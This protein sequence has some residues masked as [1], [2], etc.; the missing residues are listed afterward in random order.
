MNF[1]KKPKI[2]IGNTN[3][4]S[5]INDFKS[6]F[7][8]LG[9]RTMTGYT[10]SSDIIDD[11]PLDYCLREYYNTNAISSFLYQK[12]RP[13]SFRKYFTPKTNGYDYIF[14]KAIKE[15]DIFLFM[16]STFK[17]DLSDLKLLKKLKKKIIFFFVGSDIVW[18]QGQELDFKSKGLEP[19]EFGNNKAK[20]V[21]N[22]YER[23]RF[24]RIAEK[25]SDL[26]ITAPALAQLLRKPFQRGRHII[27]LNKIR[28]NPNQKLI[29]DVIFSPSCRKYKGHD[30]VINIIN[31]I[32]SSKSPKFNFILV[33]G[34]DYQ[35]ALKQYSD[36]DILIGELFY[37]GGGKQQR[38]ALASGTVVLTNFDKR[39]PNGLPTDTPF[40]HV[41]RHNLK[42]ELIKI[43]EDFSLRQSIAANGRSFIEN[44]NSPVNVCNHILE[45]LKNKDNMGDLIKPTFYNEIY[46]SFP[47][48][49]LTFDFW[50]QLEN[51]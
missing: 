29:P 10:S 50:D 33:E 45:A 22:L 46:A 18:R 20:L 40:I 35:S 30:Y 51:Y 5:Q 44:Y 49:R 39:Y 7:E 27:P 9:Y 13:K 48:Y 25:Y 8:E 12:T 19:P 14:K 21:D 11:S 28:F 38:E 6:G 36:A 16:W 42:K 34:L 41:D 17:K 47:E 31:E 24:V 37:P 2:Y 3:I 23:M 32:K 26:I 43:I 1:N 15:C 4:A